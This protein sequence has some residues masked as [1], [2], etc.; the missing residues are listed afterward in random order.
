MLSVVVEP[1]DVGLLGLS[2]L[3]LELELALHLVE[4]GQ[5]HLVSELLPDAR[6]L[7]VLLQLDLVELGLLGN[8]GQH[9]ESIVLLRNQGLEEDILITLP[10]GVEALEQGLLLPREELR[11]E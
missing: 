9:V 3:L 1:L 2:H 6:H 8:A 11:L 4:P 10:F 5:L 7:L